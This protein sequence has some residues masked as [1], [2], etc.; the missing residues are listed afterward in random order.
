MQ[1]ILHN[2]PPLLMM[3][4]FSLTGYFNTLLVKQIYKVAELY[5]YCFYVLIEH[6]PELFCVED[7]QSPN[8]LYNK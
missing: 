6:H 1:N 7:G 8:L 2:F 5:L 4:Y 3:D